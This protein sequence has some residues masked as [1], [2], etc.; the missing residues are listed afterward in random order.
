[1]ASAASGSW[2]R[3]GSDSDLDMLA[4]EFVWCPG[5]ETFPLCAPLSFSLLLVSLFCPP[6]FPCLQTPAGPAPA[7][8][9]CSRRAAGPEQALPGK[10]R[11]KSSGFLMK[12]SCFE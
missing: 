2:H 4:T 9:A 8:A 3:G 5:D 10:D 12:R 11:C 1:M 7:S 6:S